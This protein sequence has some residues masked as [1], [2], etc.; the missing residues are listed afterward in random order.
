MPKKT[1]RRKLIV[2]FENLGMRDV[3]LVGGKN[4]ALGEMI[5]NLKPLGIKI[6][7]GFAITAQAYD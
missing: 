7:S 1:K 3:G 5:S 6:P 2:W 4:A